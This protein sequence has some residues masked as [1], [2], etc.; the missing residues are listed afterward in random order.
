MISCGW[1]CNG[2]EPTHIMPERPM[3]E[4]PMPGSGLILINLVQVI[5]DTFPALWYTSQDHPPLQCVHSPQSSRFR[6]DHLPPASS[7]VRTPCS[8]VP[9]PP[10]SAQDQTNPTRQPISYNS[11]HSCHG[12]KSWCRWV[13]SPRVRSDLWSLAE[14]IGK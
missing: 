5:G 8:E 2:E 12:A 4:R 11:L 3:P 1:D 10:S 6:L 13:M 14:R 9:K 7:R